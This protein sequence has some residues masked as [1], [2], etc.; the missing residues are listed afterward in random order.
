MHKKRRQNERKKIAYIPRITR[1]IELADVHF[2]YINRDFDVGIFC[3]TSLILLLIGLENKFIPLYVYL[4]NV[5]NL[6]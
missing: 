2:F 1:L 4:Y 5:L 6:V 3:P